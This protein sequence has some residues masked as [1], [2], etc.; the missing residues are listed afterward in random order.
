[1]GSETEGLGEGF[2]NNRALDQ[3]ACKKPLMGFDPPVFPG[4]PLNVQ[5]HVAPKVESESYLE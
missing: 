4:S 1:M 3:K 2:M 5:G